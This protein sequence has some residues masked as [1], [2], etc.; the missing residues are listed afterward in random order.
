MVNNGYL[1]EVNEN[2]VD[3][4]VK[5]SEIQGQGCQTDFDEMCF[6]NLDFMNI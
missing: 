5:K 2:D 1:K 4:D 3:G 6:T